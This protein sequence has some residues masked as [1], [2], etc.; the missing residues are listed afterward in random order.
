M[1]EPSEDDLR[2][3][4]ALLFASAEPVGPRLVLDAV[5]GETAPDVVMRALQA[6]WAGRAVEVVEVAGGWQFRTAADV[7]DRLRRVVPQPRRLPRA[8][9]ETLAVI[10]YHQPCTRAEI[11]ERRGA[12]LGQQ[13]LTVLLEAELVAPAGQKEAPGRPVLWATTPQ[14]LAQFG[15][16][17]LSDLPRLE[18]IL[19]GLPGPEG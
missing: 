12:A 18:D 15:L 2:L 10:A 19:S 4:E 14:F 8:A 16:R 11:E 9:M 1:T 3:A 5:S 7:A 13:T 17:S 6:R